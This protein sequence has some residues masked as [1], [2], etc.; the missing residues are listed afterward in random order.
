MSASCQQYSI[1]SWIPKAYFLFSFFGMKK[2]NTDIPLFMNMVKEK[3]SSEISL[4]SKN[5]L[6]WLHIGPHALASQRYP[7]PCRYLGQPQ[8]CDI[9]M[10][11]RAME[12]ASRQ[13]LVISVYWAW[14]ATDYLIRNVLRVCF[15]PCT[16]EC[17]VLWGKLRYKVE[18]V[19]KGFADS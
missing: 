9:L 8:W 11:S 5:N 19:L 6:F 3:R 16:M 15:V 2:N 12:R 13:D 1:E 18:T 7:L 4:P 14:E 17:W 10:L